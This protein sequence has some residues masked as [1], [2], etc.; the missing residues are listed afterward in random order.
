MLM[1]LFKFRI[2]R[3][4]AENESPS[5]SHYHAAVLPPELPIQNSV[6]SPYYHHLSGLHWRDRRVL[7]TASLLLLAALLFIFWP[8]D[9]EVKIARL[10]VNHMQVH[11]APIVAV[12]IS[13]VMTLKVRNWDVYSMDITR[14]EVA[15]GYRGKTLGH[16]TSEHGHVRARGSSYVEAVLELNG[17]EVFSDVVYMLEDLARGTVPFDTVT[18]VVGWLG[19]SFVK[20]PLKVD[21]RNELECGPDWICIGTVLWKLKDSSVL[22]SCKY[23]KRV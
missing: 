2:G 11:T 12:D 10:H 3:S 20:F 16:V 1:A 15:V 9:P 8:S 13:L 17:V 18:Q 5:P 22:Q 4:S 7:Y 21:I 19:F 14:F 6:V 23:W